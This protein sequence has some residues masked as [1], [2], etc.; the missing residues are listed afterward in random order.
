MSAIILDGKKTAASIRKTLKQ[1]IL[2]KKLQPA[3]DVILVGDNSASKKYIAHKQ[4]A[5]ADIG[6]KSTLHHLDSTT[7]A[8]ELNSLISELN[9][10]TQVSGILLQLPLPEHLKADTFL[11][12]IVAEKDVDGF[13]P[14]NM[15]K[16]AQN[17][18]GLRPCTPFGVMKLLEEHKIVASGK[19]AVVIGASNI[20][21][22]P[23]ALELLNAQAT[24]TVCNSKTKDLAEHIKRAD[25]IVAGIGKPGVIKSQWIKP[26][27]VVIDVGFS[28]IDGKIKGDIDYDTAAQKAS[29]ITPVPGGVGPMTVAML[30]Y[31]SV[32]ARINTHITA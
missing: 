4:Q 17:H 7:T 25:I 11:D 28:I 16:L 2:D 23:M 19:N 9:Q 8:D 10:D 20:V 30:M 3:L 29:Y 24:V 26:G 6:I 31:N 14:Y 12:K 21:G 1:T 13:H 27:A 18:A 32:Q 22:R 5:C 15:G